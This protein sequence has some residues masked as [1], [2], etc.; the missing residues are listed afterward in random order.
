MNK[1]WINEAMIHKRNRAVGG[2]FSGDDERPGV[3]CGEG[4]SD[5]LGHEVERSMSK[6][7]RNASGVNEDRA[8]SCERG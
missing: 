1:D 6:Q 3:V 2:R 7:V 4:T 5:M 8:R